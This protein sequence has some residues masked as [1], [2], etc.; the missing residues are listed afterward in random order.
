MDLPY[1]QKWKI[2]ISMVGFLAS[3]RSTHG[4]TQ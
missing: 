2:N 1:N 3:R 4:E